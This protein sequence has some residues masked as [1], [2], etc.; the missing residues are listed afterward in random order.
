MVVC[1]VIKANSED[2]DMDYFC[3]ERLA[4]KGSHSATSEDVKGGKEDD[5]GCC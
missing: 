5:W 4:N 3:E 2:D 1:L